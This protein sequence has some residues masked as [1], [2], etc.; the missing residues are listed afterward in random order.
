VTARDAALNVTEMR[1]QLADDDEL[2][3]ELV[4]IFIHEYPAQLEAIRAAIEAGEAERIRSD[5]HR[6]KG[7]VGNLCAFRAVE[8]ARTLELMSASA[9]RTELD[10]QYACVVREIDAVVQALIEFGLHSTVRTDQ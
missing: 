1:E 6:L 3:S 5:A 10:A 4:Q 2:I 8:A 7:S 9:D